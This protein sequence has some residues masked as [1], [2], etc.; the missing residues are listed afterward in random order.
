M[1]FRKF[2]VLMMFLAG[3]VSKAEPPDRSVTEGHVCFE[4][5]QARNADMDKLKD[6]ITE[7]EKALKEKG[8]APQVNDVAAAE[9][10][11]ERLLK[12]IDNMDCPKM[13]GPPGG[14]DHSLF[15][16]EGEDESSDMFAQIKSQMGG[17]GSGGR[18][19]SGGPGGFSRGGPDSGSGDRQ[20]PQMTL[21]MRE[22]I[23]DAMEEKMN[24]CKK[25]TQRQMQ[26]SSMASQG[27][28]ANGTMNM[29]MNAQS[30]MMN[31][32]GGMSGMMGSMMGGGMNSMMGGMMGGSMSS[33][34][35]N[36]YMMSSGQTMRPG[37]FNNMNSWM[38][39]SMS[40]TNFSSY[41]MPLY[42]QL[43]QGYS[44]YTNTRTSGLG[45]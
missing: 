24:K 7:L 35:A 43:M 20:G 33:M 30:P 12:K 2:L 42:M 44:P 34:F 14:G 11:K 28:G 9:H 45:I 4:C 6:R 31:M 21:A 1:D 17:G 36:P 15:G 10:Q 8:P 19:G 16:D 27:G 5:D 26:R 22:E 38:N 25:K 3:G 40:N 29:N 18:P 13:S 23:E 37:G 39:P 41:Y 32:M